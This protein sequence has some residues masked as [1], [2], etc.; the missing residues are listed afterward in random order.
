MPV[1]EEPK[2]DRILMVIA[3]YKIATAALFLAAAFGV[4]HLLNR[5]LEAMVHQVLNNSHVDSDNRIAH[6]CLDRASRLTNFELRS[7]SAICFFYALLFG[8]EGIGLYLKKRWAEYLVVIVTA[9]LLPVE[10]YELC[11]SVNV[12]K[13][14]VFIGN[15]AI[16]GYLIQVLR[17]N[18]KTKP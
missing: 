6:W 9:T 13:V 14:V 11:V 1:P 15:L 10:I 17:R 2:S 18:G 16:L 3:I 4:L 12:I 5:D 8:T 7:I